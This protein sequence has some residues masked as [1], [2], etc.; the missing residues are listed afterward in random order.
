MY[1]FLSNLAF[2]DFCYSSVITPKMLGSFCTNKMLSLSMDVL[3]AGLFPGLHDCQ[4]LLLASMAYDRYVAVCNPLLYMVVMSPGVC[5]FSLWLSP[6]A[7]ASWSP[8][9]MPSSRFTSPTAIPISSIISIATTCLFSGSLGQ[10]L[11]PAASVILPA[12]VS[13]SSLPFSLS[14]ALPYVHIAS[15]ILKMRSA[16]GRRKAFSPVAPTCWQSPYS[17]EPHLYVLTAKF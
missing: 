2:V 6:M 14:F 4:C 10:T 13:C 3:P 16:A 15:A 5:K 17:M 7:T 8:Y 1:F 9:F 12:L 11:T